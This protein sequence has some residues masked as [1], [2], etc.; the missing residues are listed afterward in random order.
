MATTPCTKMDTLLKKL[1]P[2]N[3]SNYKEFNRA[4]LIEALD[5][6]VTYALE[7]PVGQQKWPN[8]S[9]KSCTCTMCNATFG[10]G[11]DT[12]KIYST[13]VIR[14]LKN[15]EILLNVVSTFLYKV[16]HFYT[17][18]VSWSRQYNGQYLCLSSRRSGFNSQPRRFL[19]KCDIF[20]LIL[21]GGLDCIVV[22]TSVCGA[23][24]SGSNP[25]RD[26]LLDVDRLSMSKRLIFFSFFKFGTRQHMVLTLV[27]ASLFSNISRL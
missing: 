16:S 24:S 10:F 18:S 6:K 25:D 17:D 20:T 9:R 21:C 4:L 3:F 27:L 15:F 22:S 26:L 7:V 2:G 13:P 23:D 14:C 1:D 11:T 5:L 19:I 8:F 12:I